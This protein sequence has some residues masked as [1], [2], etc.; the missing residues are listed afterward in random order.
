MEI[1]RHVGAAI[2]SDDSFRCHALHGE[3]IKV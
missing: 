1:G 3:F 2:E